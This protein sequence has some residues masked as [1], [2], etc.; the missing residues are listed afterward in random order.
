MRFKW[1]YVLVVVWLDCVFV[2][3]SSSFF[4]IISSKLCVVFTCSCCCYFHFY[5]LKIIFFFLYR[6]VPSLN[7]L[8]NELLRRK[9]I[10]I[11]SS[12][13]IFIFCCFASLILFV[14]L[15]N[16][17][18]LFHRRVSHTLIHYNVDMNFCHIDSPPMTFPTNFMDAPSIWISS[19]SNAHFIYLANEF[20]FQLSWLLSIGLATNGQM[21]EWVNRKMCLMWY[22]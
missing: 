1:T 12:L 19:F 10:Q 20:S 22:H 4:F 21:F 7:L 5:A 18:S 15:S 3:S 13:D 8:R 17:F 6:Y 11:V 2:A 9:S 16:K 14:H